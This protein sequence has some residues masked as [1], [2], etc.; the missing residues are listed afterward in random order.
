MSAQVRHNPRMSVSKLIEY[1]S[2][3]PARQ[4]TILE[5]QKR[6]TSF[7]APYYRDATE[8]VCR[9]LDSRLSPESIEAAGVDARRLR[10]RQAPSKWEATRIATNAEAI[11]AFLGAV[12]ELQPLA[13]IGEAETL[14][15][16][17][18]TIV[19]VDV[20]LR[21]EC[22]FTSSSGDLGL[23]KLYFSKSRR[24]AEDEGKYIAAMMY[25]YSGDMGLEGV[26]VSKH[27]VALDVFAG[28]VFPA[29]RNYKRLIKDVEAACANISQIWPTI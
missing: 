16:G 10:S 6:P 4:R 14:V 8:S 19:G 23:L 5:Q 20:S 2:A 18:V 3:G 13:D 11:D 28:R 25:E 29:P 17:S 26:P 22:V 24:L 1:I 21:P 15:R 7:Q 12:G 9:V 27:T